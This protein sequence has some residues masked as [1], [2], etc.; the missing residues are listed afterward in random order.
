[1]TR[2]AP[3]DLSELEGLPPADDTPAPPGDEE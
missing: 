3:L 2:S 1:M